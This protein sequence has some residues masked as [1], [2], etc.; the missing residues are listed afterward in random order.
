[1][2]K[3]M[4]TV[5][6]FA[7]IAAALAPTGSARA[8]TCCVCTDCMEAPDTR[9]FADID[10]TDCEDFCTAQECASRDL[11]D[12]ACA[13]PLCPDFPL[14]PQPAPALGSAGT[15][16]AGLAAGLAGMARLVRRGRRSSRS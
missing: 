7:F 4:L 2:R 14:P 15:V 3:R 6:A 12:R 13:A 16:L 11:M 9:C 5:V 8:Q 10:D 1:M